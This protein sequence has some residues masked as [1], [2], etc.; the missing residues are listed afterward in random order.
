MSKK[1]SY[2]TSKL[3]LIKWNDRGEIIAA[4]IQIHKIKTVWFDRCKPYTP[5]DKEDLCEAVAFID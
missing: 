4:G 2:Q 5:E 3:R 1:V